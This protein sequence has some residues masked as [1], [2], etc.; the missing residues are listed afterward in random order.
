MSNPRDLCNLADVYRY[1][2]GF[3]PAD[4]ANTD[5]V[6]TLTALITAE[7]RGIYRDTG[8]EFIAIPDEDPRTFDLTRSIVARRSLPIGDVDTV[9]QVELF[10]Y[11]GT[12]SLGVIDPSLYVLDPRIREEWEPYTRI[13]F[14]YRPSSI[15]LLARGRTLEIT[16]TWGFQSVPEDIV[17][18]CAKLVVVRYFTDSAQAGTDLSDALD[19]TFS[20]SG[21]TRSALEA[22]QGY[23][24]PDFA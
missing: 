18:A 23:S 8:R 11:D 6:A 21:L 2:P 15:V 16:G 3:D 22:V 19:P 20:V 9:T 1:V 13:R 14:P 5:T 7:S 10:D 4:G 17:Q 12:T 24:D